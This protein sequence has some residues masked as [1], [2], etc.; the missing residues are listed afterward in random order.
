MSLILLVLVVAYLG[1][2]RSLGRG[3]VKEYSDIFHKTRHLALDRI[4]DEARAAG[5]NAVLGIQTSISPLGAIQEML[6]IGTASKH[7]LLPAQYS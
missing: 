6:M 7:P 2:L 5:A 3:E 4:T 1:S